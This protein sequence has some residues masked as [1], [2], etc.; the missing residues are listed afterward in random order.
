MSEPTLFDVPVQLSPRLAW[1]EKHDVQTKNCPGDWVCEFTGLEGPCWIAWSGK[2][3]FGHILEPCHGDTE[4]SA[5]ADFAMRNGIRL[6][7]EEAP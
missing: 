2:Q 1:M 3:T 4:K 7:N 6:W 5:I